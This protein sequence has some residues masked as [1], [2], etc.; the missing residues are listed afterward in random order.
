LNLEA[1]LGGV[2]GKADVTIF[3]LLV[4][5]QRAAFDLFFRVIR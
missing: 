5:R 3:P 1:L 4:H 2:L